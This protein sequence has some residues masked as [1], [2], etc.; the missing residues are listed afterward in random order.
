MNLKEGDRLCICSYLQGEMTD[1]FVTVNSPW[2]MVED[3][4]YHMIW[5]AATQT[6]GG[7]S[8]SGAFDRE[9]HLAGI[10]CGG[11]ED[12]VAILPMN[13]ILGELKNSSIDISF[14]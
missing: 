1:T 13:I 11:N 5:A 9:G 4:G 8:G 12:E 6:K 3:F 7:M 2:I 10:L 14:E